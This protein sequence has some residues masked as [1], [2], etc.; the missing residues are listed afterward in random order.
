MSSVSEWND[1]LSDKIGMEEL[2]ITWLSNILKSIPQYKETN[3]E[4]EFWKESKKKSEI[5]NEFKMF[6]IGALVKVPQYE[7]ANVDRMFENE[8]WNQ[9]QKL[10]YS[11][12]NSGMTNLV[13]YM[14]DTL[15]SNVDLLCKCLQLVIFNARSVKLLQALLGFYLTVLNQTDG[16]ASDGDNEKK[17]LIKF[18]WFHRPSVYF[19]SHVLS[20]LAFSV[21]REFVEEFVDFICK[22]SLLEAPGEVMKDS[23][24]ISEDVVAGGGDVYKDINDIQGWNDLWG[25]HLQLTTIENFCISV[26][27]KAEQSNDM[28]G[29]YFI[30][31]RD[32]GSLQMIKAYVHAYETTQNIKIFESDVVKYSLQYS[33][34][35]YGRI[36]HIKAMVEY[37]IFLFIFTFGVFNFDVWISSLDFYFY[38]MWI[39]QAIMFIYLLIFTKEEC[40]QL[41]SEDPDEVGEKS[42]L[43]EIFELYSEWYNFSGITISFDYYEST[44]F[45]LPKIMFVYVWYSLVLCLLGVLIVVDVL[46][47]RFHMNLV[48]MMDRLTHCFITE[49]GRIVKY[50]TLSFDSIDNLTEFSVDSVAV[51]LQRYILYYPIIV[52]ISSLRGIIG[53][54]MIIPTVIF[55]AYDVFSYCY[56]LTNFNNKLKRDIIYYHFSDIW[57][58]IDV[59]I[60]VS[61]LI[62]VGARIRNLNETGYSRAA[63]TVTSISTWFKVLYYLRPFKTSGPLGK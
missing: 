45:D 31:I 28:I 59:A 57:N 46:A 44:V 52:I 30:P 32:A 16:T 42:I 6:L 22:I 51:R 43:D 35:H 5:D 27:K 11:I 25:K 26:D 39:I 9:N 37:G 23:W 7:K 56:S 24:D 19:P 34:T 8:F 18:D 33:W 47:R 14:K 38:A 41:L 53:I 63:L 12:V 3:F 58:T 55:V 10:M 21:K 4:D 48:Q 13:D 20:S 15:I 17:E 62:G 29:K 49:N 61:G 50:L 1:W 2:C 40:A 60:I 36:V 54:I